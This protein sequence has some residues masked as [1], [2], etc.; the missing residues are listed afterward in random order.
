MNKIHF[1][2]KVEIQKIKNNIE[3]DSNVFI[4]ELFGEQLNSEKDFMAGTL[5]AFHLPS[6]YTRYLNYS[7]YNDYICDLLWIEEHNIAMFVHNFDSM[8]K[9]DDQ[10]KKWWLE[11]LEKIILPWW[12]G[13]VVGHMVGGYP[14]EFNVYLEIKPRTRF[15]KRRRQRDL[16]L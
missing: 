14:R 11:D 5:D 6:F 1:V 2:S 10:I 3:K 15:F 9:N 7:W 4:A 16:R 8:L 12:D 13:D